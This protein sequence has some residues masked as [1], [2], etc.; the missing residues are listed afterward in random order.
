MS[1][2]NSKNTSRYI[3]DFTMSSVEFDDTPVMESKATAL[4]PVSPLRMLLLESVKALGNLRDTASIRETVLS[5]IFS[6]TPADSAAVLMHDSMLGATRGLENG[7]VRVK[8]GIMEQAKRQGAGILWN[9][10]PASVIC[11]PMEAFD[12]PMGVIYAE[13]SNPDEPLN[14]IHL[15]LLSGVA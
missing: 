5:L 7:A 4:S 10:P 11:V 2:E 13:A 8:R 14:N 12:N 1:R 9:D 6:I 3:G 15:N